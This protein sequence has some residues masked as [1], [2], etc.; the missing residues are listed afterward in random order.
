MRSAFIPGCISK[1]PTAHGSDG[2]WAVKQISIG[3]RVI[4][5]CTTLPDGLS[6]SGKKE[7]KGT[8]ITIWHQM[9][10]EGREVLQ[11]QLEKYMQANPEVTVTQLYKET[12][13]LRSSYQTAA[14]AGGGPQLIYGPSDQVGPFDAMGIIKPLENLFDKEFLEKQMPKYPFI[15]FISFKDSIIEADLEG[16]PPFESD[17]ED[18]E[19]VKAMLGKLGG[20]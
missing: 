7:Q 11:A 12:E 3:S 16:L 18:L 10:V 2:S 13:E 9:Q 5:I 14:V 6:F 4:W 15:G 8:K 20:E 19:N 17:R 1:K